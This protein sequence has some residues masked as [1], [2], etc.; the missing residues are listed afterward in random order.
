CKGKGM[1]APADPFRPV[2]L[3][4][5]YVSSAAGSGKTYSAVAAAIKR[6]RGRRQGADCDAN[7]PVGTVKVRRSSQNTGTRTIVMPGW[8]RCASAPTLLIGRSE[9]STGR[10]DG[11][12]G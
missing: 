12:G 4:I 8:S 3:T 11:A 1:P 2:S 5:E 7:T 9:A 6:P 10:R